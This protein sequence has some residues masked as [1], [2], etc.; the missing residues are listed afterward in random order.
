MGPNFQT[1]PPSF[2]RRCFGWHRSEIVEH[3]QR[4]LSENRYRGTHKYTIL[5][6]GP[7]PSDPQTVPPWHP[8][9]FPLPPLFASLF[10][11]LLWVSS[12]AWMEVFI[13]WRTGGKNERTRNGDEGGGSSEGGERCMSGHKINTVP[14]LLFSPPSLFP[15]FLCAHPPSFLPPSLSFYPVLSAVDTK[16]C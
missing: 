2:P 5:G 10:S 14:Q 9:F 8:L 15:G 16:P 6:S 13:P 1:F 4:T 7:D 12:G 11:L 3:W